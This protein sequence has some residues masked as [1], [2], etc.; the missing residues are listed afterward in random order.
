MK[1]I[2]LIIVTFIFCSNSNALNIELNFKDG[3]SIPKENAC[4]KM[5]GKDISITVEFKNI[6]DEAKSLA[7]IIDD[8]DAKSVAGK[9]WVHW[10]VVDIPVSNT[11]LN[12]TKK[13]KVGVGLSGKNSSGRK[14]Y[15]GMCPPNGKHIYRIKGYAL[16]DFIKKK[17]KT[18]TIER[19]EKKHGNLILES[20]LKKGSF[21]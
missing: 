7:I 18:L 10:I 20:N 16:S 9:T 8:P 1:R 19:F 15:Q 3:S 12:P 11:K 6:P 14:G 4:K 5:G 2:L 17:P 21:E 13:G